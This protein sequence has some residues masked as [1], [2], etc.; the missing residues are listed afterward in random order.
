MDIF[1]KPPTLDGVLAGF[2]KT[3]ADLDTLIWRNET[4]VTENEAA[5][6][7]LY[8]KNSALMFENTRAVKVRQNITKLIEE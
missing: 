5:L 6:H 3:L 1:K 4:Q 2:Q 7:T 8:E